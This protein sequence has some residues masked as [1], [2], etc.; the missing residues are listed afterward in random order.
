MNFSEIIVVN[1]FWS[2]DL[3]TLFCLCIL[4]KV[5]YSSVLTGTFFFQG[6]LPAAYV[7]Q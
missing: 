1:T 6:K 2:V 3:A 7:N 4:D 5:F